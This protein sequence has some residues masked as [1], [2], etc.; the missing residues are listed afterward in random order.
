MAKKKF[1]FIASPQT[2]VALW[3]NNI[4]FVQCEGQQCGFQRLYFV[5]EED[6][7][8][9]IADTINRSLYDEEGSWDF[10]KWDVFN[11]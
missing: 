8:Q 2:M 5:A 4:P 9:I 1:S 11:N 6:A 3:K 7:A 10:E